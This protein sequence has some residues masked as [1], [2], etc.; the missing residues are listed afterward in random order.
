MFLKQNA[1]QQLG[2]I[3]LYPL[4]FLFSRL[5]FWILYRISDVLYI[6]I[7]YLAGY[8]KKVVRKNLEL[9]FPDKRATE[10]RKIEK[11][12]YRHFTD[13][14]VEMVKSF[15]IS[16]PELQKRFV[17]HNVKL[18][19]NISDSGQNIIVVGGH[20]ANWEWIISL[21]SQTKASPIATYLKI[22][23]PYFERFMLKNR[24][25]FGGELIETKN[26]RKILKKYHTQNKLFI[27]GLLADQSPQLLRAKYWRSFLGVGPVPVFTGPEELA[28]QY[29]AAFVYMTIN[30]IKRGYYNV[31]FEL[32]TK[33]SKKFKNYELTDIYID[34]M[35]YQIKAAPQYYL[36]TH[37][38]F[39][40]LG[41]IPKNRNITVKNN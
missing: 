33:N 21:A 35:A 18:L 12:F 37:N 27:L 41:K 3:L 19:N 10:R 13:L 16:L 40:H 26:L 29:N 2:Y 39:K 31:D 9:V 11:Q 23:N 22:N 32:I 8:R 34:K 25:R 38:R 7:Y 5:P 15:H 20:Y 6:I 17:I 14:F 36:W 28:K 24:L 4:I 1:L 30:K